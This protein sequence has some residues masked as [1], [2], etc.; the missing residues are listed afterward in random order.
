MEIQHIR[1]IYGTRLVATIFR[2]GRGGVTHCGIVSAKIDVVADSASTGGPAKICIY[3]HIGCLISRIRNTGLGRAGRKAPYRA[4]RCSGSIGNRYIP[5]VSGFERTFR[6][7]QRGN[8]TVGHIVLCSDGSEGISGHGEIK[9]EL[10]V[11]ISFV[12]LERG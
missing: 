3:I 6:P 8:R 7:S 1:I 10:A 9:R 4:E 11:R 5:L 2:G 12:Y